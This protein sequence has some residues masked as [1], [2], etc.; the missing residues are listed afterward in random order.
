MKA[1]MKFEEYLVFGID[2]IGTE[3]VVSLMKDSFKIS[4]KV[5]VNDCLGF[6]DAP[7]FKTQIPYSSG[8]VQTRF[9]YFIIDELVN[10]ILDKASSKDAFSEFFCHYPCWDLYERNTLIMSINVVQDIVSV[11]SNAINLYDYADYEEGSLYE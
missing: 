3:R 6:E 2:E 8:F 5:S 11:N 1:K 9:V 7:F 10:Y 4:S